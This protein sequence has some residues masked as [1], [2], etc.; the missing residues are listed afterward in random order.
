ME[1]PSAGDKLATLKESCRTEARWNK[2]LQ[3]L[4]ERGEIVNEMKDLAKIAPEAV[5]DL[6]EEEKETIKNE[7]W[8]LYGKSIIQYSV[9][10]LPEWYKK[11]LMENVS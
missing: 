6:E 7:L 9:K 4:K 3:H 1:N 8:K 2:A 11:L 5:H 10:G